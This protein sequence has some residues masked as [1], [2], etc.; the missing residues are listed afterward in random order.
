VHAPNPEKAGTAPRPVSQALTKAPGH[1]KVE[2][3]LHASDA[4]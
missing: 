4:V 3:S 2:V 1:G